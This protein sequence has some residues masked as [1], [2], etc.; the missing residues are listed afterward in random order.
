MLKWPEGVRRY[1][2][3]KGP[4]LPA[5]NAPNCDNVQLA[6]N[7]LSD[8]EKPWYPYP[9]GTLKGYTGY[10][11]TDYEYALNTVAPKHGGGVEIWRLRHP[12]MPHKH[13]YPHNFKSPLDGPV[14]DGSL[15][16]MHEGNT[17]ITECAIPWSEIPGVKARLDAGMTIKFSFRVND[18]AGAGCMELAKRRSVAKRN[19]A[20][21]VDWVEHWA[22]ELEF[23]FEDPTKPLIDAPYVPTDD[24]AAIEAGG[25]S[26]GSAGGL[27]DATVAALLVIAV[28]AGAR[29]P[30]ERTV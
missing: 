10:Y 16:V 18:D 5:G 8:D 15:V 9:P 12:G 2:Y 21:R 29:R 30:S 3:R 24:L 25:C 13:F 1:S 23:A 7:V 4:L 17:R 11:D 26:E 19:G 22:N 28:A 14:K 20:F 6:F 27:P